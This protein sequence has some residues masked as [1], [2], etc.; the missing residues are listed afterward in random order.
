MLK[1]LAKKQGFNIAVVLSGVLF[2]RF[3]G[4]AYLVC[5]VNQCW[6]MHFMGRLQ[7]LKRLNKG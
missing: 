1:V 2:C 5:L 4:G 7:A 3:N 6:P